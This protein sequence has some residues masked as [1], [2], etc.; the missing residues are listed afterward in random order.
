VQIKK[1]S[2][3]VEWSSRG[4]SLWTWWVLWMGIERLF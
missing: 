4:K 1:F 2:R 3:L